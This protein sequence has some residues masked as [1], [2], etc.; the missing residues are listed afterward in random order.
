MINVAIAEDDFRIANIHEGFLEKIDGVTVVGQAMNGK[1][2]L[3]LLSEQAVDLLLLDI[4]LP[5]KMGIDLIRDARDV[6]PYLDIIIITAANEKHL[7]EKGLRKGVVNYL[8]KPISLEHF[9]DVIEQYKARQSL[10][11][12]QDTID[13][14]MLDELFTPSAESSKSAKSANPTD[15]EADITNLPK[16]IDSVTLKKIQTY[17][18][19]HPA[20]ITAEEMGEKIGSSRTT[21]RRYLEYLVS[22]NAVFVE[23]DY[24]IVGRPERKYVPNQSP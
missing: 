14:N 3:Q 13:Q 19:R 24:G 18:T 4:Y 10:L 16:G 17:I 9:T 2:T 12:Q 5:D 7:L 22:I 6:Q 21:A 1:E 23:Q 11:Q 20:P 15:T 8:I